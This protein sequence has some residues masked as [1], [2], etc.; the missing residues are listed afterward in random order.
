M[1]Y[2]ITIQWSEPDD[3]FVVFLPDFEDVMQPVTHGDSYEDAL[4]NAREV[5]EMLVESSRS[6]GKPLRV[7]LTFANTQVRQFVNI[8]LKDC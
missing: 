7:H 8:F 3:C 6:E 5:L 4:K 2:T 1:K